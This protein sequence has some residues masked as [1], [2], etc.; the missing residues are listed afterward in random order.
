MTNALL[1]PKHELPQTL[2]TPTPKQPLTL[3][4]V[5]LVAAHTKPRVKLSGDST[6]VVGAT[7]LGHI[8]SWPVVQHIRNPKH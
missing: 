4:P 2:K 8:V 3:I 7:Q 6:L 1:K 5:I